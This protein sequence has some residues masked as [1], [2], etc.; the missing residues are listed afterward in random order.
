ML[1]NVKGVFSRSRG[2][3]AQCYTVGKCS[4]RWWEHHWTSHAFSRCVWVRRRDII[5]SVHCGT[6]QW[7]HSGGQVSEHH[8]Q[9]LTAR[10]QSLCR[11]TCLQVCAC[12]AADRT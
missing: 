1:L 8:R 2:V 4:C 12:P 3:I 9:V 11:S 5:H 10:R 7:T 6:W